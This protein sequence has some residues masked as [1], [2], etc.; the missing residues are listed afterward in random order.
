MD[1]DHDVARQFQGKTAF[2]CLRGSRVRQYFQLH[3]LRNFKNRIRIVH[4]HDDQLGDISKPIGNFGRVSRRQRIDTEQSQWRRQNGRARLAVFAYTIK[5]DRFEE[6]HDFAEVLRLA[7]VPADVK[8][9]EHKQFMLF[10]NRLV[11]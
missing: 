4:F 6:L 8:G 1:R 5:T 3:S 11:I 2:A 7:G 9:L 10:A